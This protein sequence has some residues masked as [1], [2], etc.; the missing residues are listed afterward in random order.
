M[1]KQHAVRSGE[2]STDDHT[3]TSESRRTDLRE[4]IRLG[5]EV[6]VAL[7]GVC[8]VIFLLVQ[9]LQAGEQI[10][11]QRR[12]DTIT[13]RADLLEAIYGRRDCDEEDTDKCPPSASIRVRSEAALAFVE[14]ELQRGAVPN[15]AKADLSQ[16]ILWEGDSLHGADLSAT[17]MIGAYLHAANLSYAYFGPKADL[18]GADLTEANLTGANLSGSNLAKADLSGTILTGANL[19]NAKYRCTRFDDKTIWPDGFDPT[20]IGEE[21]LFSDSI[22]PSCAT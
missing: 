4:N 19:S 20:T 3:G 21:M 6:I 1:D 15:L 5:L 8:T 9:I 14:M 18:T 7:V 2:V 11:R 12:L 13:R 16:A 17:R 10:E 22:P